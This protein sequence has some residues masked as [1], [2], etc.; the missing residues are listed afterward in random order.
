[1]SNEIEKQ[2]SWLSRLGSSIVNVLTL[3]AFYQVKEDPK[4]PEHGASWSNGMGVSP[5]YSPMKAMYQFSR[6]AYSN[7]CVTRSSQDLAM[8]PFKLMRGDQQIFDHPVI[9]LFT[10]PNSVTDGFLFREQF[11]VDLELTGNAYILL[12][13]DLTNPVSLFRLHPDNTRPIPD[14]VTMIAGYEYRDGGSI[15]VYPTERIIHIRKASWKNGADGELLGSGIME[16]L[17]EEIQAD[18]NA[19]RLSSSVSQQARPDILLSPK[20]AS[21]IWGEKRR[22]E[23]LSSYRRL[24]KDGGAMVLSSEV[25]VTPLNLTPR[26]IEFQALRT[27]V[28]ENISAVTGVP[29][30]VMGLPDANYATAK[31][32][33]ITYWTNQQIK[34]R[35]LEQALSKVARLFDPNFTVILDYSAI[36]ALQDVRNS[37]LDRIEKHIMN[38]MSA[39]DAYAY[40]GLTDSPFSVDEEEQELSLEGSVTRLFEVYTNEK[41]KNVIT[42]NT[43]TNFPKRGDDKKVSLRNSNFERFPLREAIKLKQDYPQIWNKGGNILGNLQFRRLR[44]I[45]EQDRSELT[46]TQEK[47]IRLREAWSARHYRDH[48]LAG[49]V[50]QIKWLT[51][52]SRGIDHMRAVIREAKKKIDE[53]KSQSVV[54]AKDDALAKYGSLQEAFDALPEKTQKSLTKKA[55]D[56]NE[57][58]NNAASKRTTKLK[59][60]AV[61]WRGIGAY[62]TNPQSVRPNVT[63][64]EQWAMG[65]VNSFLY[66]LRNGRFRS[67]KHDTDLLPKDH[68]MAG[69][70][71][72]SYRVESRSDYWHKWNKSIQIFEAQFLKES[73]RYLEG[74]AERY[75]KRA[76]LLISQRNKNKGIAEV[77][78]R[79]IEQRLLVDSLGKMWEKIWTLTGNDQLDNLY[80]ITNRDRPL[81]LTFG[82]RRILDKEIG[83]MIKRITKT[84]EKAVRQIVSKGI[85]DGLSNDDIAKQIKRAND[86]SINRARTIAQTET[87]RSINR[88]TNE[89]Y[90]IFSEAE[91]VQISKEW[92]ASRD[93]RVR[94]THQALDGQT[95]AVNDDFEIDGYSGSA[96]ANF[97]E[98]EM[99]INC[100]CTIAPVI[101]E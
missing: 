68:P 40:E 77:L 31:Q 1:M 48:R 5:T 73:E 86:F 18:I 26:D 25:S 35:K 97:G 49:V 99:D 22:G 66:A 43:V 54:K 41:K 101:I 64:A 45:I 23:I 3:R 87:T 32:A 21:D 17:S 65:R 20:N 59:L 30:S 58:V 29:S 2:A 63:S 92:I 80:Q 4:V 83:L 34:G 24:S 78:G 10:D 91:N 61:Y 69:K 90:N 89:S 51:V 37:Q 52:G 13:G 56:H 88:A 44:G 42:K 82:A 96:P 57:D 39:E 38:G 50:A 75:S 11:L 8:L 60:A 100:R 47:A 93:D 74:A 7:A 71:D 6:H 27:I 76:S 19:Q 15:V 14:P 46:S 33:S 53:K 70:E 85:K 28:R 9:S 12:V 72:K 36:D 81:D 62:K 67:G 79:A 95:V 98:P 84:S 16:S 55:E 94:E